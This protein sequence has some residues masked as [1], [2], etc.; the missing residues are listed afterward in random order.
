MHGDMTMSEFRRALRPVVEKA[1]RDTGWSTEKF[2][3]AA[4]GGP[5]MFRRAVDTIALGVATHLDEKGIAC[6]PVGFRLARQALGDV[7]RRWSGKE[8]S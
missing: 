7:L 5:V 1:M 4:I 3:A 6:R 8:P 2:A